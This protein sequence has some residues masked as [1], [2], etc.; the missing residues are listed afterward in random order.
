MRDCIKHS[1]LCQHPEYL[2]YSANFNKVKP[3]NMQDTIRT[4]SMPLHN[5]DV[6]KKVDPIS[7][8]LI[9]RID[10][11]CHVLEYLNYHNLMKKSMERCCVL[12]K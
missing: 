3:W 9:C 1:T 12:L 10:M 4:S 6:N 11:A 2:L 7:N 8:S 5:F